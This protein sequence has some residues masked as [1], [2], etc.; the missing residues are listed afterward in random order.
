MFPAGFVHCTL[1]A[2]AL[3][4]YLAAISVKD[5]ISNWIQK[6]EN[7]IIQHDDNKFWADFEFIR[8]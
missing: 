7:I 4:A 3:V 2:M 6:N 5:Q 1:T 8:C